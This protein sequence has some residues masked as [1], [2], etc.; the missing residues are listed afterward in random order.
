MVYDVSRNYIGDMH[1]RDDEMLQDGDEFQLDRGIF[2]QVG[3]ATASMEQDLTGLF[4]KRKK[5]PEVSVNEEVSHQPPGLPTARPTN[6]QPSQLRPKTLNAL[7]G[8]P[9][10]RIGRVA[11]PTKSPHELRVHS[12][13]SSWEQNRPAKRQRIESH[14]EGRAEQNRM[15]P[16][17]VPAVSRG[18]H[19]RMNMRALGT[20]ADEQAEDSHVPTTA[21]KSGLSPARNAVSRSPIPPHRRSKSGKEDE[22]SKRAVEASPK[23]RS[24]RLGSSDLTAQQRKRKPGQ[25]VQ[26]PAKSNKI[27]KRFDHESETGYARTSTITKPIEVDL[28]ED[29]TSTNQQPKQRLKLQMASRKPRK[30]LMY[31]DLLPQESS[32][33]GRSFGDASVPKR[34]GRDRTVSSGTDRRKRDP[35]DEFHKEKQDRLKARLDRHRAKEIDRENEL[36]EFCGDVPED[37]FLSQEDIDDKPTDSHT[38]EERVPTEK[39]YQSSMTGSRRRDTEPVSSSTRCS[40]PQEAPQKAIPR[41]PSTVDSTARTLAKMDDIIFHRAQ[42]RTSDF[43][44]DKD[45]LNEILP[46]GSS[47]TAISKT[48]PDVV[49]TTSSV[50]GRP[51]LSPA[52]QGQAKVLSSKDTLPETTST[53]S[54]PSLDS[55]SAFT[56]AVQPK[57]PEPRRR[58]TSTP[59]PNPH[60][61]CSPPRPVNTISRPITLGDHTVSA[62][63]LQTEPDTPP[64]TPKPPTTTVIPPTPNTNP[65]SLVTFSKIVALNPPPAPEPLPRPKPRNQPAFTKVV[66][67]IPT[68][69]PPDDTVDV[70]SSQPPTSPPPEPPSPTITAPPHQPPPKRT[71]DSLLLPAFTKVV[72][73]KPPRS[74]L[75][76]AISDTSAMMMRPPSVAL[77]VLLGV[78]ESLGG[79]ED[80]DEGGRLWGKEAWDLFGCGRDGVECSYEEFKRKEGLM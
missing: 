71:A 22:A 61:V 7:L 66:P 56:K 54:R 78:G 33:R 29:T 58:S 69:K 38:T 62:Q 32:A 39:V 77:P 53:W 74:P 43:V 10:G 67:T 40:V 36:E 37:L 25:D 35:M 5:A 9:K 27:A 13:N 8:T 65:D 48:L 42:P 18:P 6:V 50:K 46:Q 17:P 73:T 14:L 19:E 72:P 75:R 70:P 47:P 59:P 3:E 52:F 11:L 45:A 2:I 34:S 55:L 28:D 68:P 20:V 41:P 21:Q 63:D 16:P 44:E 23:K 49:A 76:K 64:T 24:G 15:P 26:V 57:A 60:L 4:E 12:E 31:R 1:W 80:G 30:K 51:V 79:K